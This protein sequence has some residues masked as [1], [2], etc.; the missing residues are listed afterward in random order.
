MKKALIS[1]KP[2][3]AEKIRSGIK[4]WE[5]RKLEIK[6][7]NEI[8]VYEQDGIK[9][10]ILNYTYGTNGVKMPDDMPFAVNLLN[11]DYYVSPVNGRRYEIKSKKL[12]GEPD[13]EPPRG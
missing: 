8:Y 13:G 7:Y 1:I 4:K 10:A 12:L 5:F 6:D 11:E 9:V 3:Y 2:I